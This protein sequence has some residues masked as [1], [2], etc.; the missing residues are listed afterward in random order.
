MT[1]QKEMTSGRPQTIDGLMKLVSGHPGCKRAN[2]HGKGYVGIRQNEDG[3]MT[4]LLCDCARMGETEYGKLL[5]EVQRLGRALDTLGI[6]TIGKLD[7]IHASTLSSTLGRWKK[8]I[9]S[10]FARV[11]DKP[12]APAPIN[13]P[14]RVRGKVKA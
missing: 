12:Q 14:I 6:Y 7:E 13:H 11:A 8:R 2:C 3:S 5:S 1:E 9:G 4:L 10:S